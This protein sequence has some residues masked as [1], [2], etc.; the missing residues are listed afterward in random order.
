MS[1]TS[2]IDFHLT[3]LFTHICELKKLANVDDDELTTVINK[4]LDKF[5]DEM[6][7]KWAN[8]GRLWR[9]IADKY[10]ANEIQEITHAGVELLM[11]KLK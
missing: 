1:R 6:I 2:E 11:E 10:A 4:H 8:K 9:R 5:T 3:G 7:N